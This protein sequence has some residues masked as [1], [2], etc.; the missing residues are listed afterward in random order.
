MLEITQ[1]WKTTY[2]NACAGVLI[3]RGVSNPANS[4][5]LEKRKA[6][7]ETDLRGRF[8]GF[9]RPALLD[10]PELKAYD[11]YYSRF[12]KTYHIQLQLESIVFKGKTLPAVATL[13]ESMFMAEV[14]DLLLTAG[15]D[16]DVLK[17]PLT[18]D[19]SKGNETYTLMRGEEQTL[20]AE[21]MFIRDG[22]GVISSVIYGPDRRTQI[23]PE[24]TSAVFTTY[25]PA[26]IAAEAV[27]THLEHIRRNVLCFAPQAATEMLEVF[28]GEGMS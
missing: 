28:G 12:K 27:R 11:S 13:V 17:T 20:K 26:G 5:E 21:D 18:L 16:L 23:R 25:A 2:P 4:P 15:H 8:T 9:D 6:G 1:E 24:T 19:V 22:E 10:L 14:E 3:L 7:L